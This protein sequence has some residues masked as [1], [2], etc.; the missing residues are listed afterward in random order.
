MQSHKSWYTSVQID[1]KKNTLIIKSSEDSLQMNYSMEV[2]KTSLVPNQTFKYIECSILNYQPQPE[3][4][5]PISLGFI[6]ESHVEMTPE[7]TTSKLG[8]PVGTLK[9]SIGISTDGMLYL[10]RSEDPV[11]AIQSPITPGDGSQVIGLGL[12]LENQRIFVTLNGERVFTLPFDDPSCPPLR[13][14]TMQPSISMNPKSEGAQ[15][16]VRLYGVSSWRSLLHS[17]PEPPAAYHTLLSTDIRE[18]MTVYSAGIEGKLD[19]GVI[20]T[21]R[22]HK[23]EWS[24][25]VGVEWEVFNE[26]F[27]DGNSFFKCTPGHGFFHDYTDLLTKP[28]PAANDTIS[29]A[30]L[31]PGMRVATTEA[32]DHIPKGSQ[33]LV[34]VVV[35]QGNPPIGVEWDQRMDRSH[36]GRDIFT[37]VKGDG[38]GWW[39]SPASLK[40]VCPPGVND[41]VRTLVDCKY[42]PKGTKG[43]VRAVIGGISESL[44]CEWECQ[45]DL[46]H[47][48]DPYYSCPDMHGWN[49]KPQDVEVLA[50]PPK[51]QA[52]HERELLALR[53]ERDTLKDKSEALMARVRELVARHEAPD[54]ES[55]SIGLRLSTPQ[56]N[57]GQRI[58][59]SISPVFINSQGLP[60]SGP[61]PRLWIWTDH[62]HQELRV[63][64]KPNGDMVA[65]LVAGEPDVYALRAHAGSI[66]SELLM[67]VV[68]SPVEVGI[69]HEPIESCFKGS[70]KRM[71]VPVG[72]Q[73]GSDA[74]TN[75]ERCGVCCQ[76]PAAP[77]VLSCEQGHAV[78]IFCRQNEEL[79]CATCGESGSPARRVPILM[80]ER[81][82][83]MSGDCPF[84]HTDCDVCEYAEHI[85]T[86]PNV[87]VLCP[88]SVV[89]CEVHVS[90]RVW[91]EHLR[92][93]CEYRVVG[94]VRCGFRCYMK[95]MDEHNRMCRAH[96]ADQQ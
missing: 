87:P 82:E 4:T 14:S 28:E 18:G 13:W 42:V 35:P 48:G 27:H 73:S 70:T 53:Q 80:A 21:V 81:L 91:W 50:Q 26:T 79:Y 52:A 60:C 3:I 36:D 59:V 44:G 24:P 6:S 62:D 9:H 37:C 94:C 88:N 41:S 57:A 25:P 55:S 8:F 38:H 74:I 54:P 68:S 19:A 67:T 76:M 15:I 64:V 71:T 56:P 78:C 84:C 12:D 5:F 2:F 16:E 45:H 89:G 93:E 63:Q 23:P 77:S 31:K 11:E 85:K 69:P 49:V 75:S 86:C 95:D 30:D 34:R 46:M 40:L 1:D 61:I 66:Q 83:G 7:L 10:G 39:V 72:L 29:L 96:F 22:F 47:D 90:R 20:G 32:V 43:V 33:G 92:T 17:L 51:A 65:D 58:T